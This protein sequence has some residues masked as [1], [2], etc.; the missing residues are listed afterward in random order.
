MVAVLLLL[1]V[2]LYVRRP[3]RAAVHADESAR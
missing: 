2:V 3:G 1:G